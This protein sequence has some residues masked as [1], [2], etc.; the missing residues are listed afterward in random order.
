MKNNDGAIGEYEEGDL[1]ELAEIERDSFRIPWTENIIL[2]EKRCS[3]SHVLVARTRQLQEKSVGGY[4]V[5]WLVADELHLHRIAVKRE[6]RRQGFASKLVETALRNSWEKGIRW[7]TLEVRRS[8]VAAFGLYEKFGFIVKGIRPKYYDD[9][10][11][12][13]LILWTDLRSL[14]HKQ[15]S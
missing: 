13:A 1:I 2:Q 9:N 8:N 11:E 10:G 5:Y 15:S 3:I 14:C 12:D 6:C 4:I 7:A